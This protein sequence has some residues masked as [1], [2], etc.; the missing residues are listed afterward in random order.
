M[1]LGAMKEAW[2]RQTRAFGHD[3]GDKYSCLIIDN[4][5]MG[6][7]DKPLQRYTTSSMATDTYE[8]LEH[9]GWTSKPRS[10]H[11]IGV[12]MGG[13]IAQE[14]G[15][16][17]PSLIASLCLISTAAQVRN[18]VGFYEHLR[19][20]INMF[21]PK[22]VD[23][24]LRQAKSMLFP[25]EWLEAKDGVTP[26]TE[27][28]VWPTNG[29]RFGAQ[30]LKKRLDPV[31]F[32]RKGFMLQAI[33]AGWHVKTPAQL[34]EIGD[35]VG[36]DRVFVMHGDRDRLISPP[37]V[38]DLENG[39]GGRESGI[40]VIIKEGGGHALMGEDWKWFNETIEEFWLKPKEPRE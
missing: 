7:S 4:I 28:D 34:K 16:A 25:Q 19:A 33:G 18:T 10:L 2:Q 15:M 1:G 29:D 3:Q 22:T 17:Y 11:I 39:F 12:S 31:K 9:L 13:M 20:R 40:T 21:V 24:S 36:R 27:D 38:V 14:F 6:E 23:E 8:I 32:T 30:E 26:F 35:K 37:H 5:G